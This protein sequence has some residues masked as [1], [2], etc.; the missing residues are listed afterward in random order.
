MKLPMVVLVL[1]ASCGRILEFL[2]AF[3]K[4]VPP[5][6]LA[7]PLLSRLSLLVSLMQSFLLP[8]YTVGIDLWIEID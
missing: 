1:A 3:E 2:N 8:N 7:L 5:F 4:D 6:L